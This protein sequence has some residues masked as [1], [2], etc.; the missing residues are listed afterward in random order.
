MVSHGEGMN[1]DEGMIFLGKP[2]TYW[3]ELDKEVTI[4]GV[5]ELYRDCF[6]SG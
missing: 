2:M 4:R 1:A 6:P 5:T 3:M